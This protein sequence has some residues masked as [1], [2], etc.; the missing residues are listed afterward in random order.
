MK[1]TSSTDTSRPSPKRFRRGFALVVTLLLM[2]IMTVIGVGLLGLSAVELRRQ[3][4]GQGS[5]TARANARLGLMVALGELQNELGDDRRVSADASIFAD[6]KNPAAV[7]VWNGWSPNLTSRSNVSTS[8]SV[9]YAEP[10]RQA[11]FRGW[12]VSSKEP[13]DTRELEWH[14][15]PPADDVARLF[16]MDDSGFELD[17]QKIKVGKGG[18]YAWAVTQENTRAK[19]NIGS[20]DK[21]RRDPGDALQAPARPHLAL[22]TMLK[23]PETDWPRRRSTVTDFPQVTLDEEYGASRET[24]GQARAH[25]TVQSNSLL[26]NTVDGGLK[27]DLSTG[28]GMKDEDFASDTWSSGD[29]TITNPFRSTSVATYKGEKNLYAPM[30]TSSQVQVL[31]DFPPASVNH[32]YQAN[33]V[34]TFD[35]LRNYYRTYLHLYEGQGGVTAFERPYSSVAT[36]QTVAGRPFGTRS[37]TSV[38]PVLD[39]VSLFFSVVGKPDGSLCVLLSPLVTVWNPYNIPMET[40]GMVIYP[41]ID[42]AVMWNWQVTKRA[43]G[44]E[45]WSGRLSQFMGEGYQNQGRS[46]RPYFYL[47]LTQSGSPGGT[48]K[49]RLE[50]GE[51]RVFC[52][53]DM[54]RRDLDPLQGA[55]G[56]TW[57]MRPVNSP[58]DITQTLKGGIQLDTRKALYPGVENFKY[59]LKSGDVLGGSNVTFGRA[60]YPF[61]MCMAD[62]W[63]IKNPGVEL[64]AEARPASGGHAALNA[65]PN[66]NFYAQIQAT[67]AFGGTDDSFTYPG[68]TFDEIRD[69]PKLVANL[70]TYHRVAQ[71]G[72]LPVSDLM[73]TTN[74]RQPFV[75]HY[76]SGARMQTGP[77]YE[78]RMQGGTSLAA[79]AMETTPS[80]KQ[81]FYGPSHSASSGRS[82]LAFFDLPRKPILS[83]A[84]LQH[85]DLSAT[86]FGNPNQI[87]NSWASPYLP[88]SGISRRATA[89][90][91]GERISPSG[92]GVY[93]ASYLA[94][95]ALFDGFYFSGASP[96]SNDPQ[97]MNGSPQV[98]DDT[99]VTERTPLKEV[100]TSFFDDPDTA[101]LAN[102]RYRPHAGGVATDELVEQLATPAGCK[103]LAA[104]LLVDGGFNINS[105]SE[106]AWATMLGSLRNMTPAT[107]GRT[108][109]SRFRHVLT[110][111]P[112]EMVENDPWSGVRTLSDEEVKKLATNLVKEVRARGPF[113]SLGE[114][115]NRRV[116]SDTATNLAGAVQAAIDASGLNKGSDYQKFDTT[117]YPNRENLPNAVTG[118]NTPGWL[119]QADVLQALAPVITPRSDTFTIRAC[120]EATDAAGK[121]VSRV[122]LEAVVQRMPGWIDPTDR[123]E[124]ATADLV[125]QSNKKFG[126]RFEIVGV[127]EI[128]PETLN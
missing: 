73:F 31:L 66:L 57:R 2:M 67:R 86:A 46:S 92:L 28:F 17:A 56:R 3:S 105:T 93:D 100:L 44:K 53:A 29:R 21:A 11:G 4:N 115:V 97:R 75:N 102:P 69:S 34:P 32:K 84:G 49:I 16:G 25:F 6:T 40:E 74:P 9:D 63:Q 38:Q 80:G 77:H 58:N 89:S 42:F 122:I 120:G 98:W 36:P 14:N 22:S 51:V 43:G 27:T 20:D 45:T 109:Q 68:F 19:I 26:T 70:L 13:A 126:R 41:W 65:E 10:K 71:S 7:G 50:P 111:A 121:V 52:L 54:A 78:M 15:S 24:L 30:V 118:L 124:T 99:Q 18:N 101:P 5:S 103:Q 12:L 60:N 96:V 90:A 107:A 83:L 35:L 87:G 114:F 79:L 59:Q 85:C 62:G 47:H 119:S 76:L 64:M 110:G 106:E 108:P 8:P 39:R 37:Q 128:H 94:N 88:A 1:E 113:L 81:A 95:E 117:P 55:A 82:H 123:P 33:G 125:S 48:S 61:I 127:R 116:S 104:H 91:N 23:Q 112:A 72:G